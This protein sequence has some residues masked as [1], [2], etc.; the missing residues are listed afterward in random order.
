MAQTKFEFTVVINRPVEDVFE[1]LSRAE[2]MPR[3]AE[4]V[5]EAVQTSEGRVD[6]GTTCHVV[7]KGMGMQVKQDF[8]VTECQ[9]N[10]LYAAKSTSG[11][12]QVENRYILEADNGGTKLYAYSSADLGGFMGLAGPLL[13]RKLKKQFETDHTN[14]KRLLESQP[15][16]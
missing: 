9:Q 14:L 5:I 11:P 13:N 16:A 2:N 4:N 7:T 12:V 3:W 10:R 15:S 1:F 6:V 8:V